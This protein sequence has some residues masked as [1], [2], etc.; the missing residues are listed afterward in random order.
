MVTVMMPIPGNHASV[1][2]PRPSPVERRERVQRPRAAYGTFAG[3][4]IFGL[5]LEPFSTNAYLSVPCVRSL[6]TRNACAEA[7]GPSRRTRSLH[8][9]SRPAPGQMH[10]RGRTQCATER[11][12]NLRGVSPLPL[13]QKRREK[14]QV[15]SGRWLLVLNLTFSNVDPSS[16]ICALSEQPDAGRAPRPERPLQMRA[17]APAAGMVPRFERPGCQR[18]AGTWRKPSATGATKC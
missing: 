7:H 3:G 12:R 9:R 17:A 5:G 14:R 1:V 6:S 8:A 13:G 2:K 10:A 15:Y 4:D 18:S 16:A 11:V